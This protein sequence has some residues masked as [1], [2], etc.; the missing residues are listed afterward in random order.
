M[1]A[2]ADWDHQHFN[3]VIDELMEAAKIK[4]RKE[5]AILSGLNPA[6]PYSWRPTKRR[7]RPSQPTQESLSQIAG[8]LETTLDAL[9]RAAG[10]PTEA[11]DTPLEVWPAELRELR[12]LWRDERMSTE[13]R[14]DLLDDVSGLIASWRTKLDRRAQRS[15]RRRS[16]V[17]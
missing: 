4:D 5:L 6:I 17:G 12:D 14:A 16:R 15:D 2:A 9:A 10:R 13:D 7:P 11:K 3:A 8:P 1:S